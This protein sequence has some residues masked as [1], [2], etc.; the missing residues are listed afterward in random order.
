MVEL[1]ASPHQVG[2]DPNQ[3]AAYSTADAAIV[4][5]KDF[6]VGIHNQLVVDANFAIFVDD[7]GNFFAMLIGQNPIEQGGFACSEIS[8]EHGHGDGIGGCGV[9]LGSSD[10][11]C[12][13]QER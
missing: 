2:D 8:S 11:I 12:N 10:H 9:G 3:I 4:H 13:L 5:F 6:F 7:H 1:V